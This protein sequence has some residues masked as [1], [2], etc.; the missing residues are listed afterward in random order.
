VEHRDVAVGF[1]PIEFPPVILR[2]LAGTLLLTSE[3]AGASISVNGEKLAQV[4]PAQVSLAPGTYTIT[5][6]KNGRQGTRSVEVRN[7]VLN[8]LKVQL[9]Q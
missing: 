2:L 7:G 4:T 9:D 6:E 1:G 3:P 8:Y 5:V